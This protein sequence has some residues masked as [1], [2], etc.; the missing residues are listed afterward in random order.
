MQAS[1]P[2]HSPILCQKRWK[3]AHSIY[4]RALSVSVIWSINRSSSYSWPCRSNSA[5][6]TCTIWDVVIK[7]LL[8]RCDFITAIIT[9]TIFWGFE[10]RHKSPT[11]ERSALLDTKKCRTCLELLLDLLIRE[12]EAL[13][14]IDRAEGEHRPLHVLQILVPAGMQQTF[15]LFFPGFS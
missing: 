3:Y 2:R 14:I 6:A 7:I 13:L 9:A 10:Y 12:L 8:R 15:S 11:S 4:E 5:L 1:N